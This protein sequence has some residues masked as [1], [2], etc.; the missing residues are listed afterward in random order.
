MDV[1][2]GL[3]EVKLV[4][5]GAAV[6]IR[7]KGVGF[8]CDV[9]DLTFKDSLTYY[10]HLNSRQHLYNSGLKENQHRATLQEVKERLDYLRQKAKEDH[11]KP[12]EFDISKRLKDFR[13]KEAERKKQRKEAKQAK[14]RETQ[15][16]DEPTEAQD[17]FAKMMG[18][19]SFGSTKR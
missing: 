12:G 14:N 1:Y 16:R 6:G 2:E 8:Y 5:G 17:D 3:G 9:C 13:E 19:S 18:F 11:I 15:Q 4:P 10:D 7:G